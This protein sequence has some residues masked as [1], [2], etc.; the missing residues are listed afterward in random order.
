MHAG[1]S[2]SSH[3]HNCIAHDTDKACDAE[4][5]ADV[6]LMLYA[7]FSERLNLLHNRLGFAGGLI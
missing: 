5:S 6:K 7:L 3:V 2:P 4:H 1:C